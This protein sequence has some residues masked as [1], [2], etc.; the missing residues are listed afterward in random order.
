MKTHF[1]TKHHVAIYFPYQ[2]HANLQV[3]SLPWLLYTESENMASFLFDNNFANCT[4]H[5][6]TFGRNVSTKEFYAW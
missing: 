5:L 2:L 4:P 1:L 3:V 6:I